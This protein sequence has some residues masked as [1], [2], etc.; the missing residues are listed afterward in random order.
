[1]NTKKTK[2]LFVYLNTGGGHLAP[3]RAIANY[4]QK[5]YPDQIETVLIN[6]MEKTN[7]II[8]F[9]LEDCYRILQDKA[10]WLYEF[11]YAFF[12]LKPV[13]T[14]SAGV[15]V[16]RVS[17]Y[18]EEIIKREK[19][20][21]IVVFHFYLIAPVYHVIERNKLSIPVT[22]VVTDPYTAH[23]LWF[24]RKDQDFIV[25]S[26]TLRNKCI[27]KG[28]NEKNL[29]VLPFIVNEKFSRRASTE[30]IA[31]F[32]NKFGFP[33]KPMVL[34]LGG[35]DGIP[36]GLA[37][38]KSL[39]ELKTDFAIA[40]VCGKNKE[41]FEG[42]TSLKQKEGLDR[43]KVYGYVDFV[44][45][46]ISMSD[47]VITKCGASTFM[48]ILMLGKI[49]VVSSYLWEQ[50]KGNVDFL[51]ENNLGLYE[52]RVNNLPEIVEHLLTDSEY[53]Q[54]FQENIEKFHLDNGTAAAAEY[55]KL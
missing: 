55:I 14:S 48:E 40:I 18:L 47:I 4:Y 37:I 6:P 45:E 9:V 5:L 24:L 28:I 7:K 30:D 19:P 51:L 20:D 34:I 10:K 53:R 41:L 38:L 43:V 17:K 8:R 31:S 15:V 32:R 49:P 21:K 54:M 12:K 39:I 35:G 36:H 33:D 3:A 50:E 42:A 11:I 27:A 26:K 16:H 23:P 1:M 2:Y 13:S 44:Y 22:T 46:L 25:F 29:T 52:N